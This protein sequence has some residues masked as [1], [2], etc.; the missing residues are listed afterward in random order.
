MMLKIEKLQHKIDEMKFYDAV[1]DK[2]SERDKEAEPVLKKMLGDL[3]DEQHPVR[4]L[5]LGCGCGRYLQSFHCDSTI[6]VDLSIKMLK[7]AK[8]KNKSANLIEAD[9]SHLPFKKNSFD[10]AYSMSVL[11]EHVE[12]SSNTLKE[13]NPLIAKNGFFVFTVVPAHHRITRPI[14][15]LYGQIFGKTILPRYFASRH[16]VSKEL[17]KI[18]YRTEIIQE[19]HSLVPHFFIAAKK[20]NEVEP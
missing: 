19:V 18:G 11:G 3:I 4:I 9:I 2:Y 12:F 6:C 8:Q 10:F 1:A 14:A 15:C 13:I 20:L 7:K 16:K 17:L 5:D